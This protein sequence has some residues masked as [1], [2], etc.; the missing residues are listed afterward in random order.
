[1]GILLCINGTGILNRW[2]R[3]NMAPDLSYKRIDAD[4][5]NIAP[6]SNGLKVLPFG[7]GA[8]RMLNNKIIGAH[9]QDID[10]NVHTRAH[11][12]RATQEGIAFAFGMVSILCVKT[13]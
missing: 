13:K 3:D 9:F 6:G 2:V 10:L 8:E 7:N 1:M 5:A 4:A 11:I 12:F